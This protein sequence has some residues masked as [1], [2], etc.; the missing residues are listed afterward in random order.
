MATLPNSD[1]SGELLLKPRPDPFASLPTNV[2]TA[3]DTHNA[4]D[5]LLREDPENCLDMGVN[6]S[7][8]FTNRLDSSSI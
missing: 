8:H 3:V 4:M 1:D 2:V 6:W 7:I 5:Y